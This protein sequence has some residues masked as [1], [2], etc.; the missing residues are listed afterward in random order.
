MYVCVTDQ[1][2]LV[3][4]DCR[5][6]PFSYLGRDTNVLAEGF[7]G[8][9]QY[10]QANGGIRVLSPIMTHHPFRFIVHYHSNFLLSSQ[11]CSVVK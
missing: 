8:S 1:V 7:H 10:L 11:S 4:N 3:C 5:E 2:D 6:I 9:S